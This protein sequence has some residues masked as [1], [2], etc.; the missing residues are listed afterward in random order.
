VNSSSTIV[1]QPPITPP[2]SESPK[3]IP[4]PGVDIPRRKRGRPRKNPLPGE[5]QSPPPPP[6]IVTVAHIVPPPPV[7]EPVKP[8]SSV[9]TGIPVDGVNDPQ[10]VNQPLLQLVQPVVTGEEGESTTVICEV[11]KI[12]SSRIVEGGRKEYFI[13]W[14][15]FPD[16][17]CTWEPEHHLTEQLVGEYEETLKALQK[18]MQL[19]PEMIHDANGGLLLQDHVLIPP[20]NELDIKRDIIH[21]PFDPNL[22]V[23]SAIPPELMMQP[24]LDNGSIM[25]TEQMN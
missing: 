9:F 21:Q 12:L 22:S 4:A 16:S 2:K 20:P 25:N 17:E 19:K 6:K 15:G 10:K 24:I 1:V 18:E 7:Q 13:K 11:E 23:L 8:P 3:N 5:T 14:Q